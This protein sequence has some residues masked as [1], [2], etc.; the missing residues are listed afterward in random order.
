MPW[1]ISF[2]NRSFIRWLVLIDTID[3]IDRI[4]TIDIIDRI[5]TTGI[6]D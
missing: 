1:R 2:W 3:I 4:D 6:V 5:D